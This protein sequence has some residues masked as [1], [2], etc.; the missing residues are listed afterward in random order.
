MIGA[1]EMTV[2]DKK[3]LN[4][5]RTISNYCENTVCCDCIANNPNRDECILGRVP[6]RWAELL[7]GEIKYVD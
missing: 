5:I 4:A 3:V 6:R 2:E 7:Q 1:M